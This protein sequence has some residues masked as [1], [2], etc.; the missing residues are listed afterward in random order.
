MGALVA[1]VAVD[2]NPGKMQIMYG[3]D[4]ERRS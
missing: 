4:G 3:V 2:G 1:V